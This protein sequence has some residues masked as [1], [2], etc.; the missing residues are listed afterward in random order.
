MQHLGFDMISDLA[1]KETF[2]DIGYRR[3]K[4]YSLDIDSTDDKSI[5]SS[6][7]PAKDELIDG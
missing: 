2:K 3:V 5:S 7:D 4:A 1:Q 6:L